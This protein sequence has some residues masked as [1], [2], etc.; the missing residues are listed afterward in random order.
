[1]LT[2][3]QWISLMTKA[4]QLGSDMDKASLLQEIAQKMPRTGNLKAAYLSVAKTITNDPDY[5]KAVRAVE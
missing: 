3:S 4:G 1:S 2:D 5:G